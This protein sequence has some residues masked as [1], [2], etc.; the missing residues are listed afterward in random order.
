MTYSQT[1]STYILLDSVTKTP[2]K[3]ATIL[4]NNKGTI[5]SPEGYFKVYNNKKEDFIK[6]SHVGY[7]S[8]KIKISKLNLNDTIL[9][10][11]DVYSLDEVVIVDYKNIF[12]EAIS[13]L[14]NSDEEKY[15]E[16][17]YYKEFLK[18]NKDYVNYMESVGVRAIK[19][20][21]IFIKDKRATQNLIDESMSFKFV[22][23][24]YLL[25]KVTKIINNIEIGHQEM[26]G[27]DIVKIT[28]L[29]KSERG[30]YSLYMNIL[31]KS[32]LKIEKN[33]L[34]NQL[35]I[36]SNSKSNF[37]SNKKYNIYQQGN[38]YS[39]DFISINDKSYLNKI[40]F[41]GKVT[42][43]NNKNQSKLT[44]VSEQIYS[45]HNR[46][47][48]CKIHY[49]YKKL[50][51]REKILKA[52]SNHPVKNWNLE[53]TILPVDKEIQIFKTLKWND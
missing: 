4:N 19:K 12:D 32:I 23:L 3:Y 5:T 17:F 28:G 13:K 46:L 47:E 44:Y 6:I 37:F 36:I 53:R 22:P 33:T 38:Y 52:K 11:P 34:N 39:I 26:A 1:K 31:N 27:H 21:Q 35:N 42:V 40:N 20:K 51:K 49:T 15:C 8:K 16:N 10:V 50:N 45:V 24:Y 30:T 29:I 2:I 25:D 41:V 14:K 18:Q 9:L 43:L 48:N 7:K